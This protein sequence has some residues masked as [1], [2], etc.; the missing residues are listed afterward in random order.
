[1][2]SIDQALGEFI[3]AW[4]AGQ[5]P[6]VDEILDRVPD[7]DREQLA[8]LLSTW[9]QVA[10]T[11]QYGAQ[12]RAD[13]DREPALQAAFAAAAESRTPLS[14]RMRRLRERAGLAVDEVAEQ[15]VEAFG[16]AGQEA[17][18]TAYLEELERDQ[19]D[20]RRLSNRL[21]DALAAIFGTDRG[22]L[23]PG[24]FAPPPPAAASAAGG[25]LCRAEQD[26]A[27]WIAD[28]IDALSEAAMA[29]APAPMDEVDRLFLGGPDG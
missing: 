12:A 23:A 20:V 8:D 17:R 25:Q 19:L 13:V 16:L 3:N 2:T 27:Q 9:L 7:A 14:A 15:V 11:P 24:P 18:T 1:M 5:R 4:N 21:L 6:D 28:D 29:P 22:L 26:R 10:P